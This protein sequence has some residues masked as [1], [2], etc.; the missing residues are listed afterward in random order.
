MTTRLST[1]GQ[2]VIP[3]E[4]RERLGLVRNTELRVE[5]EE[6]R[7][8]LTPIRREAWRRLRGALP[9]LDLTAALEREHREEIEREG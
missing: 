8:V 6:D 3:R 1:K 7:V 4:V 2:V 5:V 9:G